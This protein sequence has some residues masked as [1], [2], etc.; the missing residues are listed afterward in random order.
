VEWKYCPET[1][2]I[3]RTGFQV[4]PRPLFLDEMWDDFVS[5]ASIKSSIAV[6]ECMKSLAIGAEIHLEP[7][8][9]FI[10]HVNNYPIIHY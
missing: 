10:C 1:D 7:D 5:A 3:K 9:K 4:P 2:Y 6:A 8:Q